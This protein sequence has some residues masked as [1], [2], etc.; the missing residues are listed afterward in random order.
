M[1]HKFALCK[2]GFNIYKK[3]QNI[4]KVSVLKNKVIILFKNLL[5]NAAY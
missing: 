3:M 2:K 1:P 5:R 4:H